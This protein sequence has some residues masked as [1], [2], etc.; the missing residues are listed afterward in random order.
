MSQKMERPIIK[1]GTKYVPVSEDT[2]PPLETRD[3]ILDPTSA[4]SELI[5]T[6]LVGPEVAEVKG[7]G[8]SED[9]D[10]EGRDVWGNSREFFLACMGFAVGLGN[11]WRFPYLCYKNGG[12][13]FLIPYFVYVICAG[14]P[15][16]FLEVGLGQFM[17]QGN[18][19]IWNICPIFKGEHA[20]S[21]RRIYIILSLSI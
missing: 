9:D 18:I 10:D 2:N 11:I 1:K 3:E 13:A 4:K 14:I 6:P 16:M 15:M 17:S 7:Q 21:P 5:L 12:G 19:S 20:K 8:Q